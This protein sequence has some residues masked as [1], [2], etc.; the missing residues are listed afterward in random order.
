MKRNCL[1]SFCSILA[2]SALPASATWTVTDGLNAETLRVGD[3]FKAT[4]GTWNLAFRR[5]NN[6]AYVCWNDTGSGGATLDLATFN[7]DMAAAGVT[8]GGN[9]ITLYGLNNEGFQNLSGLTQILVP[10]TLAYLGNGCVKGTGI[11]DVSGICANVS[12]Y[13]DTLFQN[14]KGLVRVELPA[15]FKTVPNNMFNGCTSLVE[16]KI[17][18]NTTS[19]GSGAFNGCSSLTTVYT[20]DATKVA[21]SVQIPSGVTMLNG[22]SFN[23]C[24]SIV[25]VS[26]PGVK[27]CAQAVFQ[28]CSKLEEVDLPE[29]SGQFSTYVFYNCTSL[30]R[31]N[32]PKCTGTSTGTFQNCPALVEVCVSPDFSVLGTDT[33]RSCTSFRTLYTNEATKVE[34]HVQLPAKVTGTI[35]NYTFYQTRIE[36]ID[37]PRVTGLVGQYAFSACPLLEEVHFPSVASI[38]CQH[39]FNGCPLLRVVELSPDLAG[40]IAP[41]AF[42][43][44]TSLESVY[45]SGTEPVVG[46][47]DLPA[48]VTKLDWGAFCICRS[49]EHVV[50]PGLVDI[51]NRAFTSC[52][53]LETVRV[54]PDV[55]VVHNNNNSSQAAF[56]DCP[57]LVD[58]YP[59][60]FTKLTELRG[61]LFRD[62]SSLTNFFDFSACTLSNPGNVDTTMLFYNCKKV[63][64]VRLPA[65]FSR[66]NNQAFT[67]MKPGA[68]IHFGGGIPTTTSNNN[69]LYQGTAGAGNRFKLFVDAKT[70]PAW[71][72][73]TVSGATFTP[74][75][76]AMKAESDYP[77]VATLGYLN[78]QSS[79]QNNWLVQEP[80]YV[81]ATFLDEDGATVLGV[82]PTLLG[83]APAWSGA[84]PKKASS[85]QFDYAFAGWSLDGSTVVDLATLRADAPLSL[86]AVYEPSTRSYAVS[87]EWFDGAAT[88]SDSTTVLYGE[89]PS[90]AAVE[91]AATAEHTYTF[92]GWSADGETVLSPLSAV[93]GPTAYVAVFEEKDAATTAT[94][95][96]LDDDG[97]TVLGTT[98]PD[99]GTAA[100]AP[101]AP[102]K[103]PTVST[104]YDFAG[105]STDG[106]TVLSD[107][108]VAADADFIAVYTPSVRRYTVS[109]VNWDGSAVSSAA[110]GYG[111]EAAAVALPANP[112][113]AADAEATYAF[114]GWSP[115][116]ADVT[117]DAT[118]VATYD[119]T[120]KTYAATFVDW[121]GTV[122]DGPTDYAVGTAVS[123]PADPAR[124][125]HAFAGWSP[126]V[127]AMPAAATTYTATYTVNKYTVKW[128]NG[129][130]ATTAKYDYGTPASSIAFPTGEKS[131]TSK[132][133]YRFVE[134][135]P[136]K[137]TVT[138]NTTYTA[139]FSAFVATPMTLALGGVSVGENRDS[140]SVSATLSGAVA[141][142][143]APA[144]SASA[145]ARRGADP[146]AS[147]SISGAAVSATISE[148]SN[149]VGYDWTV[150]AAQD[151]SDYGTSD[152][153][154]LRGR[155]YAKRSKVWFA[156]EDVSWTDGA[157]VPASASASRQQVRVLASF[158][159][160]EVAPASLPDAAGQAVGIGVKS[161]GAVP[162]W[163]GWTG[164]AWVRLVG[165]TPPCGGTA[166]VLAVVD[167]AARTPTA[168][169]YADGLPLV[170]ED[171]EWAVPLSGAGESLSRFKAEFGAFGGISALSADCDR[172]AD[173]TVVV[174]R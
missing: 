68:E 96:W 30:A 117:G 44:C 9:P 71:T 16:V 133:Y 112:S 38:G 99:L 167:F 123:A 64:G 92:L 88:Q 85:A 7:D 124:E 144:V 77:G 97:E 83:A 140:I 98:W 165:A 33:F 25:R 127:G 160:P 95:R 8:W 116:V 156:D 162:A 150:V 145:S 21:G 139:R 24:S 34:G 119:A 158:G 80:F 23:G 169:W 113:R 39:A 57:A 110:Y 43:N 28:N 67:G 54:S 27:S 151:W 3:T 69:G 125:G 147:A 20:D 31:V 10:D 118:Y 170:T 142:G 89:T 4:D 66:L 174:V 26:A 12:A 36:R 90:H 129:N 74:L 52:K 55:A 48:G 148:A 108:T 120:P 51:Q 40:T 103:E 32:V 82:E 106:E 81:D 35:G 104:V 164:S 91:R 135:T 149:G 159:V 22:N 155:S 131:S 84:T 161:V 87:W 153:A 42:Y 56:Y 168:T 65:G 58:F 157:F 137:E 49:I 45:Q 73:G 173:A 15:A 93:T 132:F 47:V 70:F 13:G 121:D 46:L 130:G 41:S 2:L 94:V 29:M 78:Y 126:A 60:T 18:P 146:V 53:L 152:V 122:L 6:A 109:F 100:V 79:G 102:E 19:I 37:A 105:W 154:V 136:E 141:S 101:L 166:Q 163:F 1:L 59:S 111:T 107:L 138:S 128:V 50:A 134:W 114:A 171:G 172:G 86:R 61:G 5:S 72:N 14:C 63:P 62:C 143:A 76:E 115:A 17:Q 11:T 75:T